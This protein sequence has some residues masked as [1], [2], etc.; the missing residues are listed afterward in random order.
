MVYTEA[1][2][3][4]NNKHYH[5]KVKTNAAIMEGRRQNAL[6]YYYEKV[7]PFK[8]IKQKKEKV[9]DKSIDVSIVNKSIVLFFE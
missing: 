8:E 3:I 7:K 5:E 4:N 9:K 1:R 6:K 2:K